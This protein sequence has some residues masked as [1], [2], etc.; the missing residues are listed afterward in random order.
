M[1]KIPGIMVVEPSSEQSKHRAAGIFARKDSYLSQDAIKENLKDIRNYTK[2]NY[3]PLLEQ[4]KRNLE[5]FSGIKVT[6]AEN[7]AVAASRIREIA[8]TTDLASI[9]KSN[10]VVNELRPEL[11]ALGLNTHL[12]YFTEFS[13]FDIDTFKKK[14]EDYWSVPGIHG[15][16]LIESF[17]VR[18]QYSRLNPSE[19][20]DYVA[21]LGVNA[22]SAEDGALFF[23]QHMSNIS[24][25]LE[26]ARK[27]ILMGS[28][29]LSIRQIRE[30]DKFLIDKKYFPGIV[31]MEN[32]A[33]AVSVKAREMLEKYGL[34]AKDITAAV[35]EAIKRKG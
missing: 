27:I 4:L 9:N 8:G 6:F 20:R 12:R 32:A 1:Q 15:R 33:F 14:V 26:Q 17:E 31:L 30:Y 29:Y 16:G 3:A 28:K 10:V 35:R 23:L 21:I 22:I 19:M 7:S 18:K 34:T 24:K 13:N 11:L 2:N 25:D 5:Q